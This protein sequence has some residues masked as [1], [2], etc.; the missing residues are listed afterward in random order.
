MFQFRAGDSTAANRIRRTES[1]RPY[2]S[3][4]AQ[5]H[6]RGNSNKM[7]KN[8]KCSR[9]RELRTPA[10]RC[11][12]ARARCSL[13]FDLYFRRRFSG[14][15]ISIRCDA[16]VN[17]KYPWLFACLRVEDI[18]KYTVPSRA[19]PAEHEPLWHWNRSKWKITKKKTSGGNANTNLCVCPQWMRIAFRSWLFRGRG[20]WSH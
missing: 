17:E 9:I 11:Q 6:E 3:G 15:T 19:I 8:C 20:Q 13:A 4:L 2:D 16:K 10:C 12:W 7:M 5:P 1:S 18:G 14:R